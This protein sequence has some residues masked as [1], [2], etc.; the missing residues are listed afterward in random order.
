M[1]RWVT[2]SRVPYGLVQRNGGE[3]VGAGGGEK[4]APP[5]P[6]LEWLGPWFI[7]ATLVP[8]PKPVTGESSSPREGKRDETR[9]SLTVKKACF[10]FRSADV[11][12]PSLD[13]QMLRRK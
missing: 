1:K 11:F 6:P 9:D 3:G 7:F 10:C 4:A 8:I 13:T 5:L 2:P 12:Q